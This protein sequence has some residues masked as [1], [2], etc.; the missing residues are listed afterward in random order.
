MSKHP[1]LLLIALFLSLTAVAGKV[2]TVSVE[3][4]SMRKAIKCL[5]ITPDRYASAS[6]ER[7]P[8]VYLLHGFGGTYR[9]WIGMAPELSNYADRYNVIIACPDGQNSWYLDSPVKPTVR[10]ETFMTAELLPF[11]DRQ[12]RTQPDRQ[13]RAITGLSMGGHGALFLAMRHRDL[14][15][16][17]ASLSGGVDFRPFPK[18]WELRDLL[19]DAETSPDVWTANT[20]STAADAIQNGELR[21][22]VDCGTGD[23]FYDVN[24]ALHQ[25]LLQR[26]IAHDYIERP[27]GHTWD[28][29]RG[30]VEYHLLFFRNGFPR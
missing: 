4:A 12:Y 7:F 27:G 2:D 1:L 15:S 6:A 21:L 23:F 20:V 8:V 29:W 24:K 11:L 18:N 14:Y 5:V 25:K 3:S 16:Q 28:Y 19:G 26:N 9:D 30:N 13:H 22:L 17:A 10:F